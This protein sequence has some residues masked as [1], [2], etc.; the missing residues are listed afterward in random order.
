M[1]LSR[2]SKVGAHEVG[3]R[4]ETPLQV[5]NAYKGE[6]VTPAAVTEAV[7]DTRAL[8]LTPAQVLGNMLVSCFDVNGDEKIDEDEFDKMAARFGFGDVSHE[9]FRHIDH[10]K[11]GAIDA[12]E[13]FRLFKT[14]SGSGAP[15]AAGASSSSPQGLTLSLTEGSKNSHL[16]IN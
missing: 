1:D 6:S 13:L 7:R 11:S 5:A 3:R 8:R 14:G 12:V 16:L 15:A 4:A 10:N 2:Q 9:L